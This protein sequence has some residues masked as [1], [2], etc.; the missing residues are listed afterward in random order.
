MERIIS[1]DIGSFPL[2][3]RLTRKDVG[4]MVVS[5]P[6]QYDLLVQDVMR[7]KLLSGVEVLTYPQL[8]DMI[9]Q[10]LYPITSP[11]NW[12]DEPLVIKEDKAK[13]HEL[14]AIERVAKEHYDSSGEALGIRVCIT[15]PVELHIRGY[16]HIVHA[17]VLKSLTKS[18]SNF[19]EN[20]ILR[21][22]HLETRVISIDE[23]SLGV[24]PQLIIEDDEL[25]MA[26]EKVSNPAKGMD[27][28][29]HLHSPLEAEKIYGVEGI[30]IFGVESAST[31]SSLDMISKI[32]L[33]KYDKF[34]RVGIARTDIDAMAAEY[35]DATGIDI[36]RNTSKSCQMIDDTENLK[37]ITRRL[38]SAYKK[39]GNRIKYA[40]PDCGLGGF[41]DNEAAL[42]LLKNAAMAVSRFNEC[43][44]VICR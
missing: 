35:R 38:E 19:V 5:D 9:S 25:L 34:L 44:C 31:P 41:I 11:K 6:D 12:G 40:G 1:D 3:K 2:P 21:K 17:D 37:T 32:D 15:G 8:Q 14:S 20:G 30:N 33:D 23:P 4:R 29:I 28:Q 13:I 7:M 36:W 18:L 26:L 10:F 27:V 22:K 42:K 16:G 24:D 43:G 39:F